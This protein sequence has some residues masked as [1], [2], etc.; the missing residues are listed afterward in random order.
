MKK[1]SLKMIIL[2]IIVL[3]GMSFAN[4]VLAATDGPSCRMH[5]NPASITKGGATT[6]IW[7][8]SP[9]VI[10]ATLYPKGSEHIIKTFASKEGWWWMSGIVD[11]REYTLIVENDKGETGSCDAQVE[12]IIKSNDDED[13]D[14]ND[15]VKKENN[16]EEEV[17]VISKKEHKSSKCRKF[18]HHKK[19]EYKK[20]YKKIKKFKKHNKP[21]YFEYRHLYKKYRHMSN[22]ERRHRLNSVDYKKYKT[23]KRYKKYK[24]YKKCRHH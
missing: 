7:Y 9:D 15:E 5:A 22:K 17:G 10:K 12:V 1:T 11:S 8:G 3:G 21:T 16:N 13:K 19:S 4:N 24:K 2:G 20:A 18:N 14:N 23:Y 6:V